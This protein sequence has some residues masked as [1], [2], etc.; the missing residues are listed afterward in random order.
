MLRLQVAGLFVQLIE[1]RRSLDH[2][3][4]IRGAGV[5]SSA[6]AFEAKA[7]GLQLIES[8]SVVAAIAVG[9]AQLFSSSSQPVEGA[10]WFRQ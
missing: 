10:T 9:D 1:Q 7:L 5:A 4:A 8:R 2:S 6:A 3:A